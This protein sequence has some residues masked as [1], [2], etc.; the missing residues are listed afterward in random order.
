MLLRV[1]KIYGINYRDLLT[2][3]VNKFHALEQRHTY[4]FFSF[5]GISG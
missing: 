1:K 2:L 4:T 5:G 3:L